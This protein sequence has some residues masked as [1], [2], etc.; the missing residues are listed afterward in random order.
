MMNEAV[1]FNPEIVG[2]FTLKAKPK[3]TVV[4]LQS[5]TNECVYD[6]G[7]SRYSETDTEKFSKDIGVQNAEWRAMNDK[8]FSMHIGMME[9][10]KDIL[11][12]FHGVS[13]SLN[14]KFKTK[15]SCLQLK[16][17]PESF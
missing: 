3:V 17:L 11:N 8:C 1:N 7:V 10:K 2:G 13:F 14:E 15:S 16:K 12:L 9:D 5:P 4:A 6:F